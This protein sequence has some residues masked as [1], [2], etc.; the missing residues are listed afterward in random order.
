M[1]QSFFT[2]T[3]FIPEP[4]DFERWSKQRKQ[5]FDLLKDKRMH[6]REELVRATNAQNITA[7]VSELR[8]A[9]GVID[10]TRYGGEI[11]YQL[12]DMQDESTV[13]QGIHC[14]TCRCSSEHDIQ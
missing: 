6:R 10:C 7:V 14:A 9:G 3:R 1:Q 5:L 11:Y 4:T 12:I 2:P 13:K 8:H